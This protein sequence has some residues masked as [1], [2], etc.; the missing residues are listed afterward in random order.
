[1]KY[2]NAVIIVNMIAGMDNSSLLAARLQPTQFPTCAEWGEKIKQHII[3]SN[4]IFSLHGWLMTI[5]VIVIITHLA[6]VLFVVR[7]HA[8][9]RWLCR[10][11]TAPF[12]L[13]LLTFWF[14][15]RCVFSLSYTGFFQ[16]Q[17]RRH[18]LSAWLFDIEPALLEI[19]DFTPTCIQN[20]WFTGRHFAH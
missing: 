6:L 18:G 12:P 8:C 14:S 16:G 5:I 11:T 7:E 3:C 13:I 10:C 19:K 9:P 2:N 1:M 20:T 15:C 4:F 17:E